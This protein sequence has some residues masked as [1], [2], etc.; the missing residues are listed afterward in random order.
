MCRPEGPLREPARALAENRLN[1]RQRKRGQPAYNFDQPSEFRDYNA[2]KKAEREVAWIDSNLTYRE[3][4]SGYDRLDPRVPANRLDPIRSTP[5]Q[6]DL[7]EVQMSQNVPHS[8]PRDINFPPGSRHPRDY[9][10]TPDQD[11]NLGN[12]RH[13]T[14]PERPMLGQDYNRPSLASNGSGD[15][16]SRYGQIMG[17]GRGF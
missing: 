8:S 17:R 4:R 7:P 5:P 14:P 1:Y 12:L 13:Y 2:M 15:A 9:E 16:W 3:Y 10:Y 6:Y 11:P